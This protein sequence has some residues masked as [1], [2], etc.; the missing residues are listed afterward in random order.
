MARG[1][2][3]ASDVD[4]QQGRYLAQLARVQD[5][6]NELRVI[7]SDRLSLQASRKSNEA[8][9]ASAKLAVSHCVISAPF[10]CRIASVD[11]EETQ[12]IAAGKV[13]AEADGVAVAEIT[14]QVPLGKLRHLVPALRHD[15]ALIAAFMQGEGIARLGF[16]AVVRLRTEDA[17]VE[18]PGRVARIK[19]TLDATTRTVGVIVAV[20]KPYELVKPGVRPPLLRGMFCAVELSGPAKTGRVLIPRAALHDG[21]VYLVEN[22]RLRRREVEVAFSIQD[23]VC[24]SKGL[25]GN[26]ALVV[27]DPIPAI[28]GMLLQT[29]PDEELQARVKEV[30]TGRAPL[31]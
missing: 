8:R 12:F 24:L 13:L 16:K 1:T 31:R 10:D 14:A 20:D 11:F 22:E 26:E 25:S 17:W 28:D 4:A 21:K 19:G 23:F 9:L 3:T 2:G 6:Q 30:A 7:P 18:W 27:S 5:L 15:A 29:R